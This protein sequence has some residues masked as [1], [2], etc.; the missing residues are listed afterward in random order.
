MTVFWRKKH[1]SIGLSNGHCVI[2]VFIKVISYF[3]VEDTSL[4]LTA[5]VPVRRLSPFCPFSHMIGGLK[6]YHSSNYFFLQ[7]WFLHI[8]R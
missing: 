6:L 4:V 3:G 2:G 5:L 1:F 7:F 8:K